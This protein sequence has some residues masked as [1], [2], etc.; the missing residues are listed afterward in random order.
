MFRLRCN[1]NGNPEPNITWLKNDEEPKRN[2]GPITMNK[3][4]LRVEDLIMTDSGNYKCIVCNYLGCIDH[5]FK[6]EVI[7]NYHNLI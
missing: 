7:G 1:A 4:Q 3:W 5:T 6:V 2:V